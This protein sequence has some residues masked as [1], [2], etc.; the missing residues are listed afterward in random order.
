MTM[1]PEDEI[2]TI[3]DENNMVVAAMRRREMRSQRLPHRASY[4][5]VFNSRS[6][7]Y[8]QKR[9]MT[10][11]IYPG[12]YDLAAGGVVL[13]DESYEACAKRE[14]GEELGIHD[15]P[16]IG[17]G[18]FYFEDRSCRIWGRIYS[19]VFDGEMVLQAEEVEAGSFLSIDEVFRRSQKEPFTPDGV[20]ALRRY[21]TQG[22]SQGCGG[23]SYKKYMSVFT[24]RTT[25][26]PTPSG[27]SGSSC[28]A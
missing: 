4:V 7:L 26:L 24:K 18:D 23:S 25:H 17:Q 12:Y 13:A 28:R 1:K 9:T 10:K 22:Q 5:L 8:V 11:D 27:R 15:C 20:E 2:V 21:L 16:L 14:L 6:Q 19:C 3:V